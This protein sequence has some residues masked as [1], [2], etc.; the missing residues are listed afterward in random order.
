M[1][2][3]G[4]FHNRQWLWKKYLDEGLSIREIACI[5]EVDHKTIYYYLKKYGINTER[6]IRV[7][8]EKTYLYLPSYFLDSLRGFSK[9]REQPMNMLIKNVLTDYMLKNKYNIF[10]NSRFKDK[11][12]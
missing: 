12:V 8:K 7:K 6:K 2:K 10:T 4:L 1:R 5:C 9:M 3:E 11:N